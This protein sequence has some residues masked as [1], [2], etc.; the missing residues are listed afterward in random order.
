VTQLLLQLRAPVVTE[1]DFLDDCTHQGL[2]MQNTE[3]QHN[4]DCFSL[5]NLPNLSLG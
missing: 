4:E 2:E 5:V 3:M 1:Q